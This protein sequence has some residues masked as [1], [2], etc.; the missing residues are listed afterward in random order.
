MGRG[1]PLRAKMLALL[2]TPESRERASAQDGPVGN[3]LASCWP[4]LGWKAHLAW[5]SKSSSRTPVGIGLL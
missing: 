3:K 1:N 5:L 2:Q 4:L